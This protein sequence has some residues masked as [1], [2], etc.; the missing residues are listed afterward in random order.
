MVGILMGMQLNNK[1]FIV[2]AVDILKSTSVDK[3]PSD[4]EGMEVL[5]ERLL[6]LIND[7]YKYVDDTVVSMIIFLFLFYSQ[8]VLIWFDTSVPLRKGMLYL[9]IV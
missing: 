9:I 6:T 3:L 5:M 7:I 1:S 2:M 4:L 8:I